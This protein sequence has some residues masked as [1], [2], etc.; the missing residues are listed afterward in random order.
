MV[1][2]SQFNNDGTWQAEGKE[3]GEKINSFCSFKLFLQKN[4]VK[5]LQIIMC[6]T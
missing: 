2:E 1:T 6:K 4:G 5:E 3:R